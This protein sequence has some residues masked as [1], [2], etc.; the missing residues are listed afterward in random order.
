[1]KYLEQTAGSSAALRSKAGGASDTTSRVRI[2]SIQLDL[3]NLPSI[4]KAADQLINGTITDTS[5]AG[6]AAAAEIRIPRLDAV[7]LNAGMGGWTHLDW[8][9]L[10]KNM[11]TKGWLQATTYPM[12]K[13]AEQ[14]ML[15][16]PLTGRSTTVAARPARPD[17]LMG[18]VFCANVFGHY[19]L[20]HALVPLLAPPAARSPGRI[21]WE[22]S[23]EAVSWES[24]SLDDLQA[25]RTTAPYESTKR[26]MD[27]LCLTAT[28]PA[29][30]RFSAPYLSLPTTS[31]KKKNKKEKEETAAAAAASSPSLYLCH[32]GI[33]SSTIFP[34][35]LIVFYL[36]HFAMY[37]SRLIG[38]PWHV[39]TAYG[40]A[41]APAWLALAP[42][43]ELE[44][45]G[46][47]GVKYGSACDRRGDSRIK[48]TEIEGWGW[49]GRVEDR[50]A[51]ADDPAT[52]VLRKMV[53]RKTGTRD[54]TREKREDFEALG[55]EC[56]RAMEELRIK[57][58]KILREEEED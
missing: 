4:L 19:V 46:G 41:A 12:F 54:L 39:V 13:T 55:A 21:I 57:W 53:G 8:I 50:D 38:S 44:A 27:V 56:W 37:V 11:L 33:V 28:L 40:G 20:A 1:M 36:Y 23:V 34:L 49:E 29:V 35:P 14:G 52:G 25:I 6:G 3:C 32:P 45:A 17:R 7:I 42:P 10:T 31:E 5:R 15:V 22:S 47:V 30:R 51:L 18:K 48:K 2:C 9:G 58:M 43:A 24:L 16:D 26:L